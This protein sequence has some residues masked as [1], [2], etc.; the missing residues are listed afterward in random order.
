MFTAAS[1]IEPAK[2]AKGR[3]TFAFA[4]E[5][6]FLVS[7]EGDETAIDVSGPMRG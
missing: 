3:L 6:P 7:D 4:A 5:A 2:V 1:L